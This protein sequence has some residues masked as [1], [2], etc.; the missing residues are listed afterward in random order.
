MDA[1]QNPNTLAS[2]I[3]EL[4]QQ[5]D[6]PEAVVL[7]VPRSPEANLDVGSSDLPSNYFVVSG[8]GPASSS[9]RNI[10][11]QKILK[12]GKKPL[13]F[14]FVD[15]MD[16]L[17]HNFLRT[18]ASV[19]QHCPDLGIVSAWREEVGQNKRIVMYPCPAFPYQLLE[20]EV[21]SPT[22]IRTEALTETNRFRSDMDYEFAVWNLINVTLAS[23]WKAAT[24]PELLSKRSTVGQVA[25][26]SRDNMYRQLL[27]GTPEVVADHAQSVLHLLHTR[28][29]LNE[30][31]WRKLMGIH[32][33]RP[34]DLLQAPLWQQLRMA[35]KFILDPRRSLQF[36]LYHGKANLKRLFAKVRGPSG[37]HHQKDGPE[38]RL[39]KF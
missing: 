35:R 16:N 8:D 24:I 10:G 28:V 1:T 30:A 33:I 38:R 9:M 2:W 17:H 13:A 15:T 18:C 6:Q 4:E 22:V 37:E 39:R 19:L 3:A 27:A 23:G 31:L 29:S 25:G 32:I 34:R 36:L 7:L 26:P 11:I 12:V 14:A 5:Q 21:A 20:N